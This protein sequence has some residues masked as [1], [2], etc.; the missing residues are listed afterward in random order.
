MGTFYHIGYNDGRLYGV[1]HQEQLVKELR[2]EIGQL[3]KEHQEQAQLVA[4]LRGDLE[5]ARAEVFYTRWQGL[6]EVAIPQA[7]KVWRFPV[8]HPVA[9]NRGDYKV[10]GKV[11]AR[12]EHKGQKF[13]VV[14]D[15]NDV[16]FILR[17]KQLDAI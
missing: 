2:A 11:A 6:H 15:N 17:E 9:K 12:Y 3:V 5:R 13:Y 7:L 14:V 1:K 4:S 16:Q 8:G 10:N